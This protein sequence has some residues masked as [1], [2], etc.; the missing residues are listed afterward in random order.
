MIMKLLNYYMPVFQLVASF[1]E[2]PEKFNDYDVFRQKCTSCLEQAILDA[3]S[4]NFHEKERKDAL[5]AVVVWLDERVLCSKLEHTKQWSTDLLQRKYCNILIGGEEFF[6]RLA[7][8][9]ENNLEAKFVFLFC[10][11]QGFHGKFSSHQDVNNL[12]NII[13]QLRQDCLPE[14]WQP[15]PNKANITSIPVTKLSLPSS[16]KN[17]FGFILLGMIICYVSMMLFLTFY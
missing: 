16:K 10:L 2:S 7:L 3:E 12:T 8:Q 17:R 11:Q 9:D 15:W 4:D 6:N 14:A 13:E 5:L 1:Y